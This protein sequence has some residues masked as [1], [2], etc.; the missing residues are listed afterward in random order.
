M[1]ITDFTFPLVPKH[2]LLGL[3]FGAMRSGRRGTGSDVAGSRPY[4]PGDNVHAI[5]W[6][7][8]ARLSSALGSDEF[9]VRE[10][11][12]EDAPRVIV[13][14]DR[15]PGMALYPPGLPFLSKQRASVVAAEMVAASGAAARGLVGYL[16][17]AE[18]EPFWRSPRSQREALRVEESHLAYPSFRA[19]E[20]NLQKAVEHLL[21]ARRAL[22]SG[23][24]VF[25][26]S[27]FLV[28]PRP[29]TWLRALEL[30]W[31]VV[32]VVIQD[33]TWEQ[34][35]PDVGGVTIPIVDAASGRA[36]T[37]RLT[38]REARE[39]RARNEERFRLLLDSFL[40]LDLDPVVLSTSD[41]EEI[42]ARFL[43]WSEQRRFVAGREWRQTA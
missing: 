25:V 39:Q 24:F 36:A 8:S 12:A 30:R 7:A 28:P 43:D 27:D 33:P 16:D 17:F 32:P 6:A 2:R 31:D 3:A 15:R 18:G 40:R 4:R 1:A 34:S 35:F 41:V 42:L 10:R 22:P 37:L 9:I 20:D 14:C 19:P 11:F 29:E 13:V 5:D 21:E 26:L 23:T 38:K